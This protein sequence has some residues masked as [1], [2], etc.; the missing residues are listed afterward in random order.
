[1]IFE[2]Q[3]S[4]NR[5]AGFAHNKKQSIAPQQRVRWGACCETPADRLGQ[6]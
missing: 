6:W 2:Q 1:M 4:K 3:Q 5:A